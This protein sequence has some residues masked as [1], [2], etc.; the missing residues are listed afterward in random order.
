MI[1]LKTNLKEFRKNKDYYIN[2]KLNIEDSPI[3]LF[4]KRIYA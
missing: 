2:E 1:T 3:Y 4:G